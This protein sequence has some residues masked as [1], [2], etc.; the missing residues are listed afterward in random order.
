M[1]TVYNLD[2]L[3]TPEQEDQAGELPWIPIHVDNNKQ[4]VFQIPRAVANE[5]K[6]KTVPVPE[7]WGRPRQVTDLSVIGK[8]RPEL[9]ARILGTLGL[10]N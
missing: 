7:E 4:R 6:L 10:L 8:R 2:G 1:T 3:G 9:R 5:R